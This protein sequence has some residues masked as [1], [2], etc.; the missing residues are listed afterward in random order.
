MKFGGELRDGEPMV[1]I[2]PGNVVIVTTTKSSYKCRSLVLTVG[3]WAK[4]IL[5]P[6]GLHLPLKVS[7]KCYT[8]NHNVKKHSGNGTKNPQN[9]TLMKQINK[10]I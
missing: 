9:N 2:R 1:N 4:K 8:Y 10:L 6:L 5:P 3:P 7:K